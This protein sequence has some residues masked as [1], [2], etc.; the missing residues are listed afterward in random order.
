MV[1]RPRLIASVIYVASMIMTLVSACAMKST[2]LTILFVI[3][4]IVSLLYYILTY[5][6][7]G[8]PALKAMC[9]SWIGG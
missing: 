5:I 3:L 1:E 4:Q 7:G 9:S 8:V 2:G 6:P